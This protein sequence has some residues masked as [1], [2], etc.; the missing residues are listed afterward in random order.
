M[1]KKSLAVAVVTVVIV[2]VAVAGLVKTKFSAQNSDGPSTKSAAEVTGPLTRERFES[3]LTERLRAISSRANGAVGVAVIHVETG[4]TVSIDGAKQFP[5]Y[6]VFKLPVAI[7]V[8]KLA[9][10]KRLQLEK[11]IRVTPADVAPGSQFNLDLWR[12]P[13]ERSVLELMQLSIVRSDNTSTDKLLELIGGPAVVTER[14]RQ[15][16]FMNIDIHS[17]TREFAARRTNPNTGSA[18]DLARL[19][20]QLQKAEMLAPGNREILLGFMVRAMIGDKRL[21]GDLPKDTP[22]AD[23]TGTGEAG[24]TTNDVGLITL[25]DGKGHLAVAVLITGS[26]LPAASQE[27]LIA[28]LARL[29]FDAYVSPAA[30]MAR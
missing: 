11:K 17:S 6:S 20:A 27:K 4:R 8:L 12:K 26:K 28:E 7:T 13:V 15:L 25:P 30:A 19:L 22:V 14:M 18:E 16:G 23:K 2:M 24:S 1:R 29:A 3:D 9:E 5:L 21:R 10:E